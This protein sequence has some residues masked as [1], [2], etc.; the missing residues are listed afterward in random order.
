MRNGSTNQSGKILA[1]SEEFVPTAF[2][3][4]SELS[5]SALPDLEPVSWQLAMKRAIRSGFELRKAVGLP[6]DSVE[7]VA[8]DGKLACE[9]D[10]QTFAPLE[11]VARIQPGNPDDPLL[12]QVLPVVDEQVEQAGFAADPVG[13]LNALVSPGVLHK[14]EG[15]AL[16]LTTSACGI[17]CRYCFRRE[18]P[19]LET[20]F[21]AVFYVRWICFS[22]PTALP[23][24]WN[25]GRTNR[26]RV[27]GR[28]YSYVLK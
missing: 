11:F 22:L 1:T 24:C 8:A 13:D 16:I 21:L 2:H 23:R 15:R 18:F 12:K 20:V 17:H 27:G 4:P 9:R 25:H 14:Y 3:H 7:V 26:Y 6:P 10:F 5:A 28:A 19:Y